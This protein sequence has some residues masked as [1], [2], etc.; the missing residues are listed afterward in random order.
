[1]HRL[2]TLFVLVVE[3]QETLAFGDIFVTQDQLYGLILDIVA[4][5]F[6]IFLNG[7]TVECR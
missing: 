1:M 6:H 3:L 4:T 2:Q 7:I 5:V